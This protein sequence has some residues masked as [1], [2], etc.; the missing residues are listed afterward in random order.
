MAV[1]ALIATQVNN[2]AFFLQPRN[3]NMMVY[4]INALYANP[5]TASFTNDILLYA[6]A[7]CIFM[8]VEARKLGIRHVWVYILLSF[9]VAVSVMFPLFLIARQYKIS[10]QHE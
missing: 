2:I 6:L 9:L 1:V 4:G 10:Q 8:A 5:I 3:E 7:G